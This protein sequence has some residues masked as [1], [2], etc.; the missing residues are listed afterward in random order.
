MAHTSL[1]RRRFL[2]AGSVLLTLPW[3]ESLARGAETSAAQA[4]GPSLHQL[5]AVR[6]VVLSATSREEITSP[7]SIW[8]FSNDLR[9]QFTVFSGISHPEIGGDHASEACFLTSAKHPTKG[10]FRNTVSLDYV[11]ARHVAGATRFPLLTLSTLDSSPLTYTSERRRRSG[12]QQAVGDFRA[13]VP[14]RRQERRAERNGPAQTRPK[15]AR[16]HGRPL[17]RTQENAEPATTS[18]RSPTTPKPFA[19]WNGNSRPTKLG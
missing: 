17:C 8:R 18:S 19:T 3:L 12:A 9:D 7:A 1:E 4:N 14:G 15:R 6:P 10:G 13:D 5:R 2:Q 11:A 16:S